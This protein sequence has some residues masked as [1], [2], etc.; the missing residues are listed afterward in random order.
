MRNL[1][2]L[3]KELRVNYC[4]LVV[5]SVE[6]PEMCDAFRAGLG[7]E[8]PFLSDQG[9]TAVK[10][11]DIHHVNKYG[12]SEAVPYSFS[13][14]PDLTIYKI[15]NGYWH[16]GRPTNEDLRQDYRE[17]MKRCRTDYEYPKKK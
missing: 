13:L 7:A 4:K 6:S 15:Y 12:H 9:L 17:M 5:I 14:L 10:A 8:F 16:V 2:E 1:T 3:Q 11:L